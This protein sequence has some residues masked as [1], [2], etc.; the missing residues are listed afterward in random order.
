MLQIMSLIDHEL[1]NASRIGSDDSEI[2]ELDAIGLSQIGRV[3]LFSEGFGPCF[4]ILEIMLCQIKFF[5]F[6]L[7]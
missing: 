4:F 6:T 5:Q 1:L 7:P 3:D 2:A